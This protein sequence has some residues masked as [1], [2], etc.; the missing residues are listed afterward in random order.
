MEVSVHIALGY[1]LF[2]K[3]QFLEAIR[4]FERA[5][6]LNP[7]N[8]LAHYR[9]GEVFFEQA[10]TQSAGNAFR[11]ALNGE[12][13]PKWIEPM[14]HLHL[15]K[16]YDMLGERQR[17]LAEYQRVINAKDNTFGAVDDADKYSKEPF[18]KKSTVMDKPER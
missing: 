7:R 18:A 14:S 8:S 4:E 15:G 1:E 11:D 10:N 13:Q 2:G 16:I 12:L 9:L 5:I 3:N 17:A 6:K